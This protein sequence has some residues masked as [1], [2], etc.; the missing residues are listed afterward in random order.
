[1]IDEKQKQC[2]EF[3]AS[4]PGQNTTKLGHDY[5][6]G[7]LSYEDTVRIVN[8]LSPIACVI[9]FSAMANMCSQT[10]GT[11]RHVTQDRLVRM[12]AHGAYVRGVLRFYEKMK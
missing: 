7:D 5:I 10:Q 4:R 3:E 12:H 1:M 6:M 11:A 8:D 2:Q 9:F